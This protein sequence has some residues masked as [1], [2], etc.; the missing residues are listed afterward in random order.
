MT[1]RRNEPLVELLAVS[2]AAYR[3]AVPPGW[4]GG[5]R[6]A[7]AGPGGEILDASDPASAASAAATLAAV[8][9]FFGE[10]W[11]DGDVAITNDVYLGAA[12]PTQFTAIAPLYSDGRPAGWLIGR[13]DFPDVG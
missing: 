8:R 9:A 4:D 6:A 5:L 7:I 13:A 3:A 12:H 10:E 1:S 11:C 2:E